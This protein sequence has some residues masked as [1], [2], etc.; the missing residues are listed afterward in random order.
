MYSINIKRFQPNE[1]HPLLKGLIFVPILSYLD[2]K[3]VLKLQLLCKFFY[4]DLIGVTLL[5]WDNKRIGVRK[6]EWRLGPTQRCITKIN[7]KE[8]KIIMFYSSNDGGEFIDFPLPDE[9]AN[10]PMDQMTL[11]EPN[12]IY[13]LGLDF[14][15]RDCFYKYDLLTRQVHDMQSPT[16]V[17]ENFKLCSSGREYVF[18]IGTLSNKVCEKYCIATNQWTLLPSLPEF[19]LTTHCFADF[20]FINVII[21]PFQV[22]HMKKNAYYRLSIDDPKTWE[23]AGSSGGVSGFDKPIDL[24]A[25]LPVPAKYPARIVNHPFYYFI[26]TTGQFVMKCEYKSRKNFRMIDSYRYLNEKE[27]K[28]K[29]KKM[30]KQKMNSNKDCIIF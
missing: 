30:L 27:R 20:N 11:V 2:K 18:I 25:K 14:R 8:E 26:D 7:T 24:C 23:D 10:I 19:A 5:N 28:K 29:A 1:S 4:E 15:G 17:H 6:G 3:E 21:H 22:N 9:F 16:V 12:S 13:A